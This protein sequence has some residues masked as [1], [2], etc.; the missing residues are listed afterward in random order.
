[1]DISQKI[2]I[3]LAKRKFNSKKLAEL[4]NQTTQN[5]SNKMVHNDFKISE[6]EKYA[7]AL[8]CNLEVRFVDKT[9]GEVLS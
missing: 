8:D 1:M 2:R 3:V 6:L 9:S 4:T 5:L 7:N